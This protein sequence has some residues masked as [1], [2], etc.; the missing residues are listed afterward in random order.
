[1]NYAYLLLTLLFIGCGEATDETKTRADTVA[2]EMEP[3]KSY[4]VYRGDQLV[5]TSDDA[6]I[7]IA[8][9]IQENETVVVLLEGSA[10]IIPAR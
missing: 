7:S 6:K 3:G 10:Q 2:I 1:M 4:R 9:T 5:K 8:K